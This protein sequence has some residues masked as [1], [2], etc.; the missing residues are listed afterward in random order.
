MSISGNRIA[1]C[2]AECRSAA[3]GLKD[4]SCKSIRT[5]K[6]TDVLVSALRELQSLKIVR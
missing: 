4:S 5:A 6:E 1:N 2:S 3:V